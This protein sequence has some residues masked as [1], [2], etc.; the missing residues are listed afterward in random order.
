MVNKRKTREIRKLWRTITMRFFLDSGEQNEKQN[1]D[2]LNFFPAFIVYFYR[3]GLFF[4]RGCTKI[5]IFCFAFVYFSQFV[6]VADWVCK[7]E[8]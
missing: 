3:W 2:V 1:F 5:L 7:R 6:W 4:R 8:S